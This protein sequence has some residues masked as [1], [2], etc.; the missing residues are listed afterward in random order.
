[1]PDYNARVS[2]EPQSASRDLTRWKRPVRPSISSARCEVL[3]GV[4]VEEDPLG[5]PNGRSP[6]SVTMRASRPSTASAHRA[7]LG[8]RLGEHRRDGRRVA[9]EQRLEPARDLADGDLGVELGEPAKH[10]RR[11]QRHV[12]GDRDDAPAGAR[13]ERRDEAGQRV[14]RLARLGEHPAVE[15]RQRRLGLGDDD[16]LQA[17]RSDRGHHPRGQRPAGELDQRLGRT[18]ADARTAGED[19]SDRDAAPHRRSFA[20]NTVAG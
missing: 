8:Q 20:P 18:H 2:V 12:A 5:S 13:V 19:G 11:H 9:P 17:G 16:R 6:S 14:A 15:R 7:T 1:M 3:G 10:P 4:H